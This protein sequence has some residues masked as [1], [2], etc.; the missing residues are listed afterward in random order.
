MNVM[1]ISGTPREKGNSEMLLR[2]A[3]QPFKQNGW[4]VKIFLLS[5]LTIK[6]GKTY[7]LCRETGTFIID[8]NMHIN[9][10]H[11]SYF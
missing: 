4:N 6:P 3:L 5:E 10:R 1:G 9:S 2:S 8:D 11:S 7:E